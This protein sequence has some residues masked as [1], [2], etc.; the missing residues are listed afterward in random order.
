MASY[1]CRGKKKLWSVRFEIVENFK[2]VTKRLS[3]FARKKDAEVGY[4]K[5]MEEY[6]ANKISFDLDKQR[7]TFL[8]LY[9]EYI[10]YIKQRNKESTVFDYIVKAK[11]HLIPYFKDYRVKNISPKII[12]T[13]QS[14]IDH[15]SYNYKCH[16][17]DCLSGMLTYAEKYYD[18]P[19]QLRKVDNFKNKEIKKEMSVWTPQEL[20]QVLDHI[21]KTEPQIEVF[22]YTLFYTGCRKG[23]LLAVQ[24]SD[25]N[26]KNGSLTI[27]KSVTRKVN[28][29]YWKV[30]TPKN[31]SSNRIIKVPQFVL[32][33]VNN[34]IDYK[35]SNNIDGNFTFFG[36]RP[37]PET[38]IDRK[39]KNACEKAN[40]KQIRLHDFRHSHASYLI[41]QGATIVSVA[42]RLGHSSITQTLN[43]Y[44]HLMKGDEE[45]LIDLLQKNG[46]QTT[47]QI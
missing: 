33:M 15:F 35:K 7:M 47:D 20:Q 17:R 5:F 18:I 37:I 2:V 26:F 14:T 28:D 3:G 38:N 41:S 12:L 27:N 36:S 42:K 45:K 46:Q 8:D 6:E 9:N 10:K 4:R 19:N 32:D 13:W 23:E 11:N 24:D 16:L 44:S 29:A 1:E 39:L 30:T 43:T 31:L 22:L 34:L 25:W 40:I 21:D